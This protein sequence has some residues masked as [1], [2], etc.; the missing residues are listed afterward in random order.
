MSFGYNAGSSG[1]SNPAHK[2]MHAKQYQQDAQE[3]DGQLSKM[4]QLAGREVVW[5]GAKQQVKHLNVFQRVFI[6]IASLFS[7]RLQATR[8]FAGYSECLDN[9]RELKNRVKTLKGFHADLVSD[10][11]SCWKIFRQEFGVTSADAPDLQAAA[12]EFESWLGGP[13]VAD[14][15]SSGEIGAG[16]EAPAN[17]AKSQAEFCSYVKDVASYLS[18]PGLD[19]K[20]LT[21][22]QFENGSI[23]TIIEVP[24]PVGATFKITLQLDASEQPPTINTSID[25]DCN[26][27]YVA[28][29]AVIEGCMRCLQGTGPQV[30]GLHVDVED[31]MYGNVRC[32]LSVGGAN[33][34]KAR[35]DALVN[36]LTRFS[37]YLNATGNGS[38]GDIIQA[39]QNLSWACRGKGFVPSYQ[40]LSQSGLQ[41]VD[42]LMHYA[43]LQDDSPALMNLLEHLELLVVNEPAV[44][45]V[46][47]AG[48]KTVGQVIAELKNKLGLDAPKPSTIVA[49]A[50]V[51]VGAKLSTYM[52]PAKDKHEEY[53][54]Q[55]IHGLGMNPS[56]LSWSIYDTT[57]G[58][59]YTQFNYAPSSTKHAEIR[60]TSDAKKAETL[61]A[62]ELIDDDV[63]QCRKICACAAMISR[64]VPGLTVSTTMP[65]NGKI[66]IDVLYKGKSV[67]E[68]LRN[69]M[70]QMISS[71]DSNADNLIDEMEAVRKAMVCTK[72]LKP[73]KEDLSAGG[74]MLAIRLALRARDSGD[75]VEAQRLVAVIDELMLKNPSISSTPLAVLGGTFGGA[76]ATLKATLPGVA[77]V[78]VAP[79]PVVSAALS[80]QLSSLEDNSAGVVLKSYADKLV[81]ALKSKSPVATSLPKEGT[82]YS[83]NIVMAGGSSIKISYDRKDHQIKMSVA[84][85]GASQ[86][87]RWQLL[88]GGLAVLR[89]GMPAVGVENVMFDFLSPS[90]SIGKKAL[91]A[92]VNVAADC[93]S[94]TEIGALI[95]CLG[96]MMTGQCG[97]YATDYISEV[98]KCR[99]AFGVN[100]LNPTYAEIEAGGFYLVP[101]LANIAKES[102]NIAEAQRLVGLMDQF[103]AAHPA[104]MAVSMTSG[105]SVSAA[106]AKVKALLPSTASAA[107][108]KTPPTPKSTGTALPSTTTPAPIHIPSPLAT[109]KVGSEAVARTALDSWAQK[110]STRSAFSGKTVTINPGI[111]ASGTSYVKTM[112][113]EIGAGCNFQ[114]EMS[115]DTSKTPASITTKVVGSGIESTKGRWGLVTACAVLAGVDVPGLT[116]SKPI[117]NVSAPTGVEFSMTMQNF[118]SSQTD[119]LAQFMSEIM[120][121]TKQYTE[122]FLGFVTSFRASVGAPVLKPMFKDLEN[123]AFFL[124]VRLV[125]NARESGNTEEAKR[126]VVLMEKLIAKDAKY[127]KATVT[128][129]QAIGR[130]LEAEKAALPAISPEFYA[131]VEASM[132]DETGGSP[133]SMA[134]V[135][136]GFTLDASGTAPTLL[137]VAQARTTEH[138][139]TLLG[140]CGPSYPV[141]RFVQELVSSGLLSQALWV[142]KTQSIPLENI[143]V[144]PDVREWLDLQLNFKPTA[145]TCLGELEKMA[146]GSCVDPTSKGV[147]RGLGWGYKSANLTVLKALSEAVS[148]EC[149]TCRIDVPSF[150]PVGDM[151]MQHFIKKGYPELDSDWAQFLA[152][153]SASDRAA[154]KSDVGTLV[155]SDAAK[156]KLAAIRARL[157]AVV[158]LYTNPQI[159]AWLDETKPAFV[160]VRSTG[161]EDSDTNSNAGGNAS[162][163]F[164]KPNVTDIAKASAEV[165]ASYFGEKSILQRIAAKDKS[166]LDEPPFMP[167]LIQNMVGENV[168]GVDTADE[169]VPRSGVMFTRTGKGTRMTE[170]YVGL[171]NNEGVVSSRVMTDHYVL[172]SSGGIAKGVKAK[173][174]RFVAVEKKKA[175][176]SKVTHE[177]D[178]IANTGSL[179]QEA[180]ALP[181]EIAH[182]MKIIADY[183]STRYGKGSGDKALDMEFTI[184]MNEHG[185]PVI[186]LLQARPLVD[187]SKDAEPSYIDSSKLKALAVDP[188]KTAKGKTLLDGGCYVR[189]IKSQDHV[190]VCQNVTE[191]LALYLDSS[192]K[193]AQI[194]T[195]II[196][197]PAPGT[198]HE[199]VT[200]R[201]R[202]V[203]ILVIENE[204]AF[205]RVMGWSQLPNPDFLVD[206]QRGIVVKKPV[207]SGFVQQGYACYPM[208]LEYSMKP[209][210]IISGMHKVLREG[211]SGMTA[212]ENAQLKEK[213]ENFQ[214]RLE[215]LIDGCNPHG[216]DLTTKPQPTLPDLI[217]L[218]GSGDEAQ[219]RLA[220]ARLLHHLRSFTFSDA[221]HALPMSHIEMT[222]VLE[223]ITNIIWKQF[224]PASHKAPQSLDRLYPVRLVEACL[225]QE[226]GGVLGGSSYAACLRAV[227]NQEK[228]L[229]EYVKK[230]GKV[231]VPGTEESVLTMMPLIGLQNNI[232]KPDQQAIWQAIIKYLPSV[233]QDDVQRVVK[234]IMSLRELDSL[235]EWTNV[236]LVKALESA[237][238]ASASDV[239]EGATAALFSRL[240]TQAI[241]VESTLKQCQTM[242]QQLK[243]IRGQIS[244]WQDP[245]HVKKHLVHL[246]SEFKGMGFNT[247]PVAGATLRAQYKAAPPAAR[248]VLLATWLEGIRT[249][250]EIIKTFKVSKAD[251]YKSTTLQATDF[252]RFLEYYREMLGAI[253]LVAK[254]EALF[255][256]FGASGGYTPIT[257]ERYFQI[258]DA[259]HDGVKCKHGNYTFGF[260]SSKSTPGF[261]NVNPAG[262]SATACSALMNASAEFN[263]AMAVVGNSADYNF[264]TIWPVSLEDYFTLFH[265]NMETMVGGLRAKAGF[266][267]DILPDELQSYCQSIING[268]APGSAK[269]KPSAINVNGPLIEVCIEVPLRQHAAKVRVTYDRS[270]TPPT[271]TTTVEMFG[272]EEH[273]RW[274][275]TSSAVALLGTVSTKLRVTKPMVNFK[276]PKSAKFDIITQSLSLAEQGAVVTFLHNMCDYSM[277]AHSREQYR[278]R[279]KVLRAALGAPS[280][281]S[282]SPTDIANGGW[283]VQNLSN[284]NP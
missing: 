67:P 42:G 252:K 217:D 168:G 256:S 207:P 278:E 71:K 166:L 54:V 39:A 16:V 50:P 280:T 117:I 273:D 208:P 274:K 184:K 197:Q 75:L 119:A 140:R 170:L 114:I 152:T 192:D 157:E 224:L 155:L 103:S 247:G 231:I 283:F 81:A 5:L 72:P 4:C 122:E 87:C 233:P 238:L 96:S 163:P 214:I 165:I 62:I 234:L 2:L 115:Y 29:G 154:F 178:A 258:V 199:A 78:P 102:G 58:S 142:I 49:K 84:A 232:L 229:S 113:V 270:K 272:N 228:G 20:I 220:A 156:A 148:K 189:D 206:M 34:N 83:T 261:N 129:A 188:D 41:V 195:V 98:K 161:K 52:D 30:M 257:I 254:D 125:K 259:A 64:D 209:S 91:E 149:S 226:V 18:L 282:P 239:D 82:I 236:E 268:M 10:Y 85:V 123:G 191:A 46:V 94:E 107:K 101:R 137:Q 9:F 26:L 60:I 248:K 14:T 126:L 141:T 110:L 111:V 74:Y 159:E 245:E 130:L 89:K 176:A 216:L 57:P 262:Q 28:R 118:S 127:G 243:V 264:S 174:T 65:A 172:D 255:T 88:A 25:I 194:K 222:M 185:K 19:V 27:S 173:H 193:Q 17:Y 51:S 120:G 203:G 201:A 99:N 143:T 15:G 187:V 153:F 198:S 179:L 138:L 244:A 251:G 32:E 136:G 183:F 246:T 76:F 22:Q 186:Y 180:P 37:T 205:S 190:I 266:N 146:L 242:R 121:S 213:F 147:V 40:A 260:S 112:K 63:V 11:L 92:T 73:T 33:F 182:D 169:D 93:V 55:F 47:V 177:C 95:G 150:L 144:S 235:T 128:S 124:G 277:S 116:T 250:D 86:S 227:K 139:N 80:H 175:G 38:T 106:M 24:S 68:T 59:Y 240:S 151:E 23:K 135:F 44:N 3:L 276:N 132:I 204:E 8:Y 237:G 35:A 196:K 167:I 145:A 211:P 215:A 253:Q 212:A 200:L 218:M 160:I 134:G 1:Y 61:T 210:A 7:L 230:T 100:D 221:S 263:V 171:G 21:H 162:I 109:P 164:I 45:I 284:P 265:Q 79:P 223:N 66:L 43:K 225:F 105:E 202:G 70:M 108:P 271:T 131:E 12:Y 133:V 281:F 90:A 56:T 77:S 31:S 97:Q 53:V 241:T 269:G 158:Q 267:L 104:L 181:D 279:V 13:D 48:G 69:W 6:W 219:S 249:Y 275:L 36:I